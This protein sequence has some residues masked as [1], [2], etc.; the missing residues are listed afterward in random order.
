MSKS[1]KSKYYLTNKELLDEII[2]SKEKDELTEK[3]FNMLMLLAERVVSRL[4]Y[5]NDFLREEA[6]AGAKLDILLYWKGF[7]INKGGNAFS[8][9]TSI[10]KNGA[11]KSFN[12]AYKFGK[13]FKG[14]VISM[15]GSH[16]T[17]DSEDGLYSL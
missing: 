7:D 8:Y 1:K 2:K 10:V 3:A 14:M 17:T 11:A 12:T 13:K 5:V 6:L 16:H 9:Y 4:P 15:D